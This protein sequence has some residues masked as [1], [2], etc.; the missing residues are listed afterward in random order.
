MLRKQHEPVSVMSTLKGTRNGE[1]SAVPKKAWQ[2][3][4][5]QLR[6]RTEPSSMFGCENLYH[7][8]LAALVVCHHGQLTCRANVKDRNR[9]AVIEEIKKN[10]HATA[11]GFL[12]ISLFIQ[13]S[14]FLYLYSY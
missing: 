4:L 11:C 9:V 12:F 10:P 6:S 3:D 13:L 5:F 7:V 14:L 8:D 1:H 2:D